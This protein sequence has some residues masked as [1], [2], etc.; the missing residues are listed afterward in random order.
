MATID[1]FRS[2][3]YNIAGDR[4]NLE[5]HD[6]STYM[7]AVYS[8]MLDNSFPAKGYS[9]TKKQFGT[10]ITEQ[11]V[12]IKKDAE[13]V[14]TNDKILNSKKSTIPFYA[15]QKQMLGIKAELNGYKFKEDFNN[16]FFFNKAG[17]RYR[18]DQLFIKGN[19]AELT[20]SK[21]VDGEWVL[22]KDNIKKT[23]S[24]LFELWDLFGAQFS[25][26]ENGDF[27]EGSNDLLFKV[28]TQPNTYGEYRLKDAMIHIVS[29]LS[30]VKAGGVN[31]NHSDY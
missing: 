23:F 21:L 10:L 8:M 26:D 29:N 12:T 17:E 30:A 3:V 27:N 15:K 16:E 19:Y 20:V 31:V 25:T 2:P 14:I 1:D 5:A 24:T 9:G 13:S 6:G 7:T 4:K 11:G 28:V 22:E 18:I